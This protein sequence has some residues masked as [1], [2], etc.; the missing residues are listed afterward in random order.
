MLSARFP[1]DHWDK[2]VMLLEC[3]SRTKKL[4]G[5]SCTLSSRGYCIL[6]ATLEIPAERNLSKF[7]NS[8]SM[9][10]FLVLCCISHCGK[11]KNQV[12]QKLQQL[13]GIQE[14]NKSG[15]FSITSRYHSVVTNICVDTWNTV[16]CLLMQKVS[17]FF[18]FFSSK[19]KLSWIFF[20][21]CLWWVPA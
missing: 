13:L 11:K 15:L 10:L 4:N 9:L 12:Y 14:I 21:Q 17:C 7:C 19:K 20:L 16:F 1:L 18:F 3:G 2:G 6:M 5:F 8:L